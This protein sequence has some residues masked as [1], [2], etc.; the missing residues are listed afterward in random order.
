G[1]L[2]A[3]SWRVCHEWA[4]DV[5]SDDLMNVG[6]FLAQPLAPLVLL[7]L[8]LIAIAGGMFVVPLY[9]FLTTK[10]DPSVASRMVAANNIVNSGAMVIG[11]L[12][13]AGLSAAGVPIV[14]QLLLSALMCVVSAWLG[15]RLYQAERL[16]LATT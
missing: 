6:Q 5:R 11:S 16:A 8:L 12:I 15:R 14:E 10:C 9:A 1:A 13:A 3:A 7:T 2:V 4:A